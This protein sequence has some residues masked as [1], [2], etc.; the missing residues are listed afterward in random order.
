LELLELLGLLDLRIPD[1]PELC[2]LEICKF[3]KP[4]VGSL[5]FNIISSICV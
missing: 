3:A 1:I 4:N 5:E 2:N